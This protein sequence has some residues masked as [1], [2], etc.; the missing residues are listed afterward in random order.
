M[1]AAICLSCQ[2]EHTHQ[3]EEKFDMYFDAFYVVFLSVLWLQLS[4]NPFENPRIAPKML[5]FACLL[6]EFA[7]SKRNVINVALLTCFHEV[8]RNLTVNYSSEPNRPGLVL[9][10]RYPANLYKHA[11]LK[12]M[13]LDEATLMKGSPSQEHGDACH[14]GQNFVLEQQSSG[15]LNIV[16]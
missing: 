5:Y 8:N 1:K 15:Y 4:S 6:P 9:C 16:P 10:G 2:G 13:R 14:D 12:Q 11:V 7:L 3:I